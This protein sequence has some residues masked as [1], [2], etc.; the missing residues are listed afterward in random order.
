MRAKKSRATSSE[1]ALASVH[2]LQTFGWFPLVRTCWLLAQPGG[3]NDPGGWK[4]G[5][6]RGKGTGASGRLAWCLV[7]EKSRDAPGDGAPESWPEMHSPEKHG[8]VQAGRPYCSGTAKVPETRPLLLREA[9]RPSTLELPELRSI[10]SRPPSSV[11]PLRLSET[12][13]DIT[14]TRRLRS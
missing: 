7:H 14:I 9:P 1:Y 13:P 11:S 8:N 12:L 4:C 6:N 3:G 2:N 5:A 10:V